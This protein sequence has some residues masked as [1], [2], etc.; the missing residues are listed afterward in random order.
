MASR[1][2]SSRFGVEITTPLWRVGRRE[3]R[4]FEAPPPGM[5]GQGRYDDT[6]STSDGSDRFRVLYC[7]ASPEAAFLEALFRF[8]RNL[9]AVADVLSGPMIEVSE[10]DDFREEFEKKQGVITAAHRAGVTLQKANVTLAAPVFDLTSPSALQWLRG[11]LALLLVSL[12]L[13]DLDF[14]DVLSQNRSLT[15][16]IS[17]WIR[18]QADQDGKA[19]YAGVRFRSR[20]DPDAICYALYADRFTVAGA[21]ET[22]DLDHDAPGLAEALATLNLTLAP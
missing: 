5:Q 19:Q 7:A 18:R 22:C 3:F 10:R 1:S 6:R 12:G 11:E 14:G 21:I 9:P 4:A 16:G 13:D 17:R 2:F 8:R 15:R 20:F